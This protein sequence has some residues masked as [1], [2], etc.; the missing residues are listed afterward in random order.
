MRG[1]G[2]GKAAPPRPPASTPQGGEWQLEAAVCKPAG[3]G[4][5]ACLL[6]PGP[7]LVGRTQKYC[8]TQ[9]KHSSPRLSPF[10]KG[11]KTRRYMLSWPQARSSSIF[12]AEL[13]SQGRVQPPGKQEPF[14]HS[15]FRWCWWWTFSHH[16]LPPRGPGFSSTS[17]E[18]CVLEGRAGLGASLGPAE[19]RAGFLGFHPSP[20]GCWCWCIPAKGPK[21]RF[22]FVCGLVPSCL[23]AWRTSDRF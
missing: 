1:G 14:F 2:G 16:H 8:I 20:E 3:T 10:I 5:A 18:G 22:A 6:F 12:S 4:Q 17:L 19:A 9:P 11:N 15:P 23:W 13:L 7:S 21:M